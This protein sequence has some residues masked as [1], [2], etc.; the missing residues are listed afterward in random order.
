MGRNKLKI[1][2]LSTNEGRQVTYSKR[3]G[4][5]MKKAKELSVLCDVDVLLL[6]FSNT[7]KASLCLGE[8]RKSEGLEGLKKTFKKDDHEVDVD[9]FLDQGSPPVEDL[10]K[11]VET[12][13]KQINE[14]Y[15]W[16]GPVG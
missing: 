5:I 6:A 10:Q 16:L 1:E 13:K 7:G 8:N 3:K 12:F 9:Q 2:K 4:G 11:L 15:H 14:T